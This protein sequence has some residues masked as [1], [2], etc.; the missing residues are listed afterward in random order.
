[1]KRGIPV[2]PELTPFTPEQEAV[3]I[4]KAHAVN[5]HFL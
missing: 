4:L 2:I 5:D 3:A 1:M